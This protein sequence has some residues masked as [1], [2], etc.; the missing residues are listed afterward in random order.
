MTLETQSAYEPAH[1]ILIPIAIESSGGSDETAHIRIL[2][3]VFA[4][5]TRLRL[6]HS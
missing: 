4:V 1:E 6:R 3:R 2:V 5:C